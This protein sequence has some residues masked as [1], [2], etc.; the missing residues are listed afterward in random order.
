M[1]NQVVARKN[2]AWTVVSLTPDVC[3]TPIGN[4]TPPIPYPVVAKLKDAVKV[5]KSVRANGNPLVVFDQ[6][7][8]PKTIGDAAGRANGLKSGTVEGKCYPKEHSKTVRA[9]GK[10][11]LR[12]GDEFWMNG[13]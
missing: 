5:V 12:H 7:K 4:S 1:S 2:A 11:V 6:S 3:K 13:A 10:P 8:V 9:G